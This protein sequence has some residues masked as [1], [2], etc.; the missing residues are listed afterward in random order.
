MMLAGGVMG[1][2]LIVLRIMHL[3]SLQR[4]IWPLFAVFLILVGIQLFIS[5]ILADIIIKNHYVDGKTVYNIKETFE[6]R[7]EN[8]NFS[9]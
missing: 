9:S 8:E 3:I 6:N 2:A 7:D 4:T 5:G 1:I